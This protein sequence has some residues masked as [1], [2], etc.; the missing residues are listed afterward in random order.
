MKLRYIKVTRLAAAV[1]VAL[2]QMGTACAQEVKPA[3]ALDNIDSA[4]IT[5][6]SAEK[7]N[8]VNLEQVVVTGTPMGVTKMKASVSISTMDAEQI[9]MAAP[10]SAAE[11]LRSIPGVRSESSGGEGNANVTVRGVP[12][13]AGGARYVQFQEDGLPI[14]QN[15]DLQFATPD[16]FMRVDG[17]LDHIEVVRGGSSSVLGTNAPGGIINFITKTG[18]EKGGSIGVS[19]GLGFDQM[20]YDFDYGA[21]ISDKTRFFVGGFYRTGNGARPAGVTTEDGGQIRANVTHEFDNGFIRL[22]FKHLDDKTPTDLPVPVMLSGTPGS[23]NRVIS[24]IPGIDPRT[25]SFYSPYWIKDI[26]LDRNGNRIAT[27]VND[28]LHVTSNSF[29]FES[30]FKVGDGWTVSENFRKSSNSGRFIGIFPADNVAPAAAGTTYATGPNK[31][32]PYTGLVFNPVVFNTSLDDLGNTVNELKVSKV[33]QLTDAAK[34]TTVAGLSTSNQNVGTTWNFNSYLMQASGSQPA[35]LANGSNTTGFQGVAFG[36]CCERTY[37][38][39]YKMNSPYFN[40]GLEIGPWNLDGGVRFDRQTVSGNVNTAPTGVYPVSPTQ[41]VNYSKS[42][43]SYS[44]GGNYR[45]TSN[46]AAFARVSDG[47]SFNADR[48][49]L[50]NP[51]DGTTPVSINQV[52]QNEAGLKWKQGNF[53]TFVT[54]FQAKTNESNFE[55]TTQKF[56]SNRYDGKGVELETGYRIGGFR[57]N[58]GVTYTH[59]KIVG[60]AA[61]DS[62][63]IGNAPRRQANVVYQVAPSYSFGSAVVGASVIGTTKSWADNLNTKIL[64]AF[65]VVNMFTS[66]AF[67]ARTSIA[68]SVN[69]LFNTIGYT[70]MED[71]RNAARSIN[72]RTAKVSLKYTF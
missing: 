51:L 63:T 35:L 20:R 30:A 26:V 58:S 28:G 24:T 1:S 14:L 48:I 60:A 52:K 13:S 36:G 70:E 46:L 47:V 65:A 49:L 40:T 53:S 6:S 25:A 41:I 42:N 19:K 62:M 44:I 4:K 56:T 11:V 57:I 27:N 5:A 18:E 43:T 72:G 61:A 16:S 37:D 59:A 39:Q 32:K 23:A 38:L 8:A 55:L 66:Y 69:N 33:F 2:L 71:D 9:Q 31:G 54:F 64:P 10:T 15:G 50:G 17:G 29:G 3:L 34:L 22:S 12:I 7:G 21:P 67:D 68:L 45:I